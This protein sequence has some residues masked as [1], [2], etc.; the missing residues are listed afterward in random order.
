MAGFQG[1]QRN[2]LVERLESG[3]GSPRKR[4][5]VEHPLKG[6][7]PRKV[8]GNIQRLVIVGQFYG[9]LAGVTEFYRA[10]LGLPEIAV[11]T[12]L[13]Q[14]G[15]SAK[16]NGAIRSTCSSYNLICRH[17]AVFPGVLNYSVSP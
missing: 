11:G 10:V 13:N 15:V 2:A 8:N 4:I 3:I 16:V 12:N 17:A 14:T 6:I 1:W 7:R 5:T 9:R